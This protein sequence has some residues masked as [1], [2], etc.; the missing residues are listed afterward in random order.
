MGLGDAVNFIEEN[1]KVS[2]ENYKIGIVKKDILSTA[3]YR[4][5]EF[6]VFTVDDPSKA[7][8]R[9]RLFW[10]RDH[11]EDPVTLCVETPYPLNTIKEHIA[12]GSLIFSHGSVVNVPIYHVR[13]LKNP[14]LMV[15]RALNSLRKLL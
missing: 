9:K 13:E 3:F 6:V 2:S 1:G 4:K 14:E 11:S 7:S 5:G 8:D 12:E 15:R 10:D